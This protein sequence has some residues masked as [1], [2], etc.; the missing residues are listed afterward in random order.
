MLS[1]LSKDLSVW[2]EGDGEERERERRG[3]WREEI[4][5]SLHSTR[6]GPCLCLASLPPSRPLEENVFMRAAKV[7]AGS[8]GHLG[9]KDR[10]IIYNKNQ[11][12]FFLKSSH[13]KAWENK[14]FKKF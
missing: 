9:Y 7:D 11:P 5:A 2:Q 3:G 8:V 10:Q 1:F 13:V 6:H 4:T 12:C 14:K